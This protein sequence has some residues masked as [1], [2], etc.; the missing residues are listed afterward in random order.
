TR[1]APCPRALPSRGRMSRIPHRCATGLSGGNA[2]HFSPRHALETRGRDTESSG[3]LE[4]SGKS[5]TGPLPGGE[6]GD[7]EL[8]GDDLGHRD[9]S[10][11]RA[12]QHDA[13]AHPLDPHR[14]AREDA[15]TC[16]FTEQ[17]DVAL[18]PLADALEAH[19]EALPLGDGPAQPA[20]RGGPGVA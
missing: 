3:G 18:H 2:G 5:L 6:R 19:L 11:G 7:V 10:P 4:A 16:E 8:I 9:L 14:D 17:V 13:A 1:M 15:V 12:A 20:A